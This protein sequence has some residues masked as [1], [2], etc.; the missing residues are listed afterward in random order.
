M[1]SRSLLLECF[2]LIDQ[3]IIYVLRGVWFFETA[4]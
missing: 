3:L 4:F 1:L 2:T